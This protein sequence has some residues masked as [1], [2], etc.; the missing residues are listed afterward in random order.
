M[1]LYR[2]LTTCRFGRLTVVNKTDRRDTRRGVVW[3]CVCDCGTPR[4]VFATNLIAG[5]TLSCGCLNKDR[6]EKHGAAHHGSITPEYKI[7][8]SM[9]QRC[10]KATNPGFKLYGARGI[11]VCERWKD[12]R[13]F[14]SDLGPRPTGMSI[15]RIDNS[16]GY[17]PD[18]CKWATNH[19]QTRNT[20]RNRLLT[21]QDETKCIEDWSLSAG[22]KRGTIIGRLDRGWSTERTLKTPA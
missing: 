9:I 19:E 21:F 5:K 16:K 2:D 7:W 11:S 20:R 10:T 8:S 17:G 12:F 18:N 1:A 3:A 22:L 13:N 4:E 6:K 15:E 14:W